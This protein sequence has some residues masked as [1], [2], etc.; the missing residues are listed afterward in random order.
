MS[1]QPTAD[2]LLEAVGLFLEGVS[3]G[4]ADRDKFLARVAVNALA[5]VRRELRQG[6]KAEAGAVARLK[7]LLGAEGD[8]TALNGMLCAAIAAGA[9]DDADPG[10]LLAHLRASAVDRVGIDQ[11][12]YSGLAAASAQIKRGDELQNGQP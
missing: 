4:L 6:P 11:P 2:E 7:A 9:F 8:F 1:R 12:S 5:V 10:P 3:G